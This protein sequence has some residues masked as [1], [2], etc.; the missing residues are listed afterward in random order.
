MFFNIIEFF[1]RAR[2]VFLFSLV[3][4][5]FILGLKVWEDFIVV[6]LVIFVCVKGFRFIVVCFVV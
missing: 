5:S 4:V 1:E 6:G 3:C 2:F